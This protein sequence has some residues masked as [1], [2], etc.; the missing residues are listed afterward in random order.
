MSLLAFYKWWWRVEEIESLK[1]D[2]HNL[3]L[4]IPQ[5]KRVVDYPPAKMN[6]E[7]IEKIKILLKEA[8][9]AKA[10]ITNRLVVLFVRI[11]KIN[12]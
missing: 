7:E 5:M 6:Q 3:Q 10:K 4:I 1:N 9:E 12:Y 8:I 11:S 2:L